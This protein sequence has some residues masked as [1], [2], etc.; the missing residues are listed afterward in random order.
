MNGLWDI[1]QFDLVCSKAMLPTVGLCV[2][3]IGGIIGVYLF[4]VV[5]DRL[6]WT[7]LSNLSFLGGWMGKNRSCVPFFS[8]APK[9]RP[10]DIFFPVPWNGTVRRDSYGVVQQRHH[11]DA[12]EIRRRF[13]HTCHL[14]NTVHHMCVWWLV[15][16]FIFFFTLYHHKACFAW[17]RLSS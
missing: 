7:H 16:S 3:N 6:V 5:S 8:Y 9:V 11:L 4:G 2:L 14:P 1:F 13:D 12:D 15:F 10:Q 17:Q